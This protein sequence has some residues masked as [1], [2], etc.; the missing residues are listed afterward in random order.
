MSSERASSGTVAH[1]LAEIR[2]FV[3]ER[4]WQRFHDA[5]N[6]SML[7]ASEAGE[8]T[9]V[10]RWVDSATA[11]AEARGPLR[12]RMAE[13]LGDVGIAWF[14][15]CDRLGLDPLECVSAKLARNRHR[16]PVE[17]SRGR[18]E[19]PAGGDARS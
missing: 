14:L 1:V 17:S 13:E 9:A 10:L 11:D 16:Y 15:L 6:L 12:D 4:E 18:A 3:A 8:L 19:R 2:T 5:K 7:L